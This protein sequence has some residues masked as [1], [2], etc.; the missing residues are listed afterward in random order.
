[1][2][3]NDELSR[4]GI[5]WKLGFTKTPKDEPSEWVPATVPGA[6]QLDW[7]KAHKW[8]DHNV[9]DN[10]RSYEW[11][12]DVFWVYQGKLDF[13]QPSP[14]EKIF[15]VCGGVDYRFQVLLKGVLLHDQEGMYTPFE[16]DLTG[17]ARSGDSIEVRIW[18]VPK[19]RV[20]PADRVQANQS[21]KPAVAYG[22]DF[23]P[24]LVPLGI[25][26]DTYLEKRP[27]CHL[28]NAEISYDLNDDFSSAGL[29]CEIDLSAAGAGSLQWTMTDP[30]GK[31]VLEMKAPADGKKV[32]LT[33]SVGKPGLWWP[34]GQGQG[35]ALLYGSS[36]ELK[37]VSGK[38]V[39]KLSSRVGFRKVRL[40]MH[41]DAWENPPHRD[42]PKSRSNPPITLEIN[43]REIFCKGS[44]WVTPDIFPG[45]MTADRYA[46]Q[47]A[48]V[49][50]ANMNIVRC[51]GGAS[52]Q[53]QPFFDL[54]DEYG[55]MVWQEFPLACNRYEGTDA[56]LKVL[57]QESRTIIRRLRQHPSV[58]LWCG[59][60]ELFNCWSRMTDQDLAL[61]LLNRN[62]YDLDPKR[63]FIMTSP[64]DG[65]G[66]G[67]Y[68]FRSPE[69]K[70]VF[71]FFSDASCTA[72][73]EFGC[74]GPSSEKLL[75]KIIPEKELFPVKEGTAWETHHAVKAW[76]PNS[77]LVL[78]VI[79]RYFGKCENIG[80]VVERGQFLQ[81]VG[82][83]CLFEEARRQRPKA[84]MA[85]NWCFNEPWPCAANMSIVEWPNEP[86]K[87]YYQVK[88]SLRPV[89][90]SAKIAKFEW[91]E[92]DVF[93]A[94]LWLL[95]DAPE[96]VG[97]GRVEAFLRAGTGETFLLGWDFPGA[98]ANRNLPG[99]VL[100][101]Q[102]PRYETDH[103][104]L[105]LRA[106]GRQEWDSEYFVLY[107]P[108]EIKHSDAAAQLNQ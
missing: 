87:A 24:R 79:E 52:V 74:G 28:L 91:R 11:M 94:D 62:C 70:D 33:G 16:I 39:Q 56:Y 104:E 21:C 35:K 85:L 22:W 57:D 32:L 88:N 38:L 7:A 100:R 107:R 73:T 18:P 77:H 102:L 66:H 95:N 76:E 97:A 71:R 61:R 108:L 6:V 103:L 1:M 31:T 17:K 90:A 47:L 50:D 69:G 86:K 106:K 26:Q 36:V 34:N 42:F 93:T 67:H 96:A 68:V 81:G 41:P 53:K 99:P 43:G 65:M 89:L 4:F 92:G 14:G 80:Q 3:Q 82:L 84:S 64:L 25:W 60:N 2:A 40:V 55:I 19:T 44:N 20:S 13:A 5:S 46:G 15:L 29:R 27:D 48:L 49:R 37:D 10:F 12:E 98:G 59:G 83:K 23:H 51:W 30:A 105:V 54:C 58:V 101:F 78:D 45:T 9:A 72:Y 8:P 75:K 63:P